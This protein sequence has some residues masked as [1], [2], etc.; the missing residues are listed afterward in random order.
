MAEVGHEITVEIIDGQ[1]SATLW[2]E[3]EGDRLLEAAFWHGASEWAR[4]DLEWGLVVEL[5]F[6]SQAEWDKCN[7]DPVFLAVLDQV[8]DPVNGVH[9]SVG[10]GGSAGVREP[11][12]PPKLPSAGAVAL[13]DP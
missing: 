9:V 5:G 4:H 2:F 10:W 3:Q 6:P 8:P 7:A 11:R 1:F 13:P 12:R